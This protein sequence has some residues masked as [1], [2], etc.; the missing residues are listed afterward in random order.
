MR[1]DSISTKLVQ[2]YREA[3]VEQR[4]RAALALCRL[5]TSG[6]QLQDANIDA[7]LK[8]LNGGAGDSVEVRR[9]LDVL[10]SNFDEQYLNLSNENDRITTEA[11]FLFR[12]ARA[13]SALAYALSP[14]N[15]HE[16]IY[17]AIIA[18]ANQNEAISVVET[19]LIGAK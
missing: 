1:L 9:R 7:A 14:G 18:A 4:T 13:V 17:E 8:I 19:I 5:V 15:L 2:L 10:G 12:Q 3:S 11:G 6:L 16:A